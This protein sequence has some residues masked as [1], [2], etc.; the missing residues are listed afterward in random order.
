M[1][2]YD[3][4]CCKEIKRIQEFL[5]DEVGDRPG[6][7]AEHFKFQRYVLEYK[8]LLRANKKEKKQ[9]LAEFNR[10]TDLEKVAKCKESFLKWIFGKV[11]WTTGIPMVVPSCV[12]AK[13]RQKHAKTGGPRF[14]DPFKVRQVCKFEMHCRN[15]KYNV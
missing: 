10:S 15:A 2:N 4:I 5:H 3:R 12:V 14:F 13:I 11:E 7:I 9:L 6:C 8:A 1:T